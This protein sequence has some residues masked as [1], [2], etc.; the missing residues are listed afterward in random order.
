MYEGVVLPAG[1]SDGSRSRRKVPGSWSGKSREQVS[2][3]PSLKE[4]WGT[5]VGAHAMVCP[6][7][8]I[9]GAAKQSVQRTETK[10]VG[11]RKRELGGQ[12]K[13]R[14]PV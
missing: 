7:P 9:Q 14:N 12:A 3:R 13:Q 5:S 11:L 10:S 6:F 2:L 8:K 4:E 1:G